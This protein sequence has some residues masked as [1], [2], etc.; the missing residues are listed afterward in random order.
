MQDLNTNL[1]KTLSNVEARELYHQ[2]KHSMLCLNKDLAKLTGSNNGAIFLTQCIY[3]DN[4]MWKK[5]REGTFYK[6]DGDWSQEL[7][8][9]ISSVKRIRKKLIEV[10]YLTVKRKGILGKNHYVVNISKILEDQGIMSDSSE[11]ANKIVQNDPLERSERANKIGQN[12]LSH[13]IHKNTH[14]KTQQLQPPSQSEAAKENCLKDDGINDKSLDKNTGKGKL[15]EYS[16]EDFEK[17]WE[18]TP[19]KM[20]KEKAAQAFFKTMVEEEVSFED[21]LEGIK[22]YGLWVKENKV[23]ER[24]VLPLN[25]WLEEKKWTDELPTKPQNQVIPLEKI[26]QTIEESLESISGIEKELRENL[27][28]HL[29]P[30]TY[31]TWLQDANIEI[32]GDKIT[33]SSSTLFKRNRIEIHIKPAVEKVIA[34]MEALKNKW[35]KV[36]VIGE[37]MK[38]KS[39]A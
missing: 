30:M 21:L 11:R 3:W 32:E 5:Y 2:H 18:R 19:R 14:K 25:R 1:P 20:N 34:K 7:N 28:K 27:V 10:G 16:R 37:E 9:S 36:T 17:L 26:T 8:L 24:Y 4:V 31:Q 38:M 29:T 15:A 39:A 35:V 12:E 13:I 6:T 33:I 23:E 22:N